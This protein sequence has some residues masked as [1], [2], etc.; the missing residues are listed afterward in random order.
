MRRLDEVLQGQAVPVAVGVHGSREEEV[1][2]GGVE[3]AEVGVDGGAEDESCH[4]HGEEGDDLRDA[5]R[6]VLARRR[7]KVIGVV[8]GVRAGSQNRLHVAPHGSR[9]LNSTFLQSN[10]R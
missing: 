6:P 8:V 5:D 4:E 1:G 10:D 3:A 2:L 9:V 7:G